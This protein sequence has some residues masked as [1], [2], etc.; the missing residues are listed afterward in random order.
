MSALVS[1]QVSV[2]AG[3]VPSPLS[4]R[5][6]TVAYQRQPVLWDIDYDA[7]ASRLVAIVGPNGAGK[8][9]LIKSILGLLPSLSGEVRFF[10][11][12]Y[13]DVRLRVGYVPQRTSVD[14]DFPVS[15]LDVVTMGLYGRI[16]WCRPVKAEHRRLA[17]A[18]LE[19][20]ELA[21]Y[22]TRQISQLSGATASLSGTGA[23]PGCR[24]VFDGR[25][26]RGSRFRHRAV[27]RIRSCGDCG[28]PARR[29]SSSITTCRRSPNISTTWLCSISA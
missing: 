21:E 1:S 27:D 12:P 13:G 9:T 19:R 29:R 23:G 7:P 5:D 28:S 8:S 24:P 17:L 16:G 6:L 4:I 20:M 10:G 11:R 25:T 15:A 18:A 3:E 2:A 26:V 14:W 22:A